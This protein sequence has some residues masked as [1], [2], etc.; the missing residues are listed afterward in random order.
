MCYD[1]AL[2]C[3]GEVGLAS[4]V[5]DQLLLNPNAD[6]KLLLKGDT[7]VSSW[8]RKMVKLLPSADFQIQVLMVIDPDE[9]SK[10]VVK[11][12]YNTQEK[13]L[14]FEVN[15]HIKAFQVVSSAHKEYIWGV[16]LPQAVVQVVTKIEKQEVTVYKSVDEIPLNSKAA[17]NQLRKLFISFL[18]ENEEYQTK[19]SEAIPVFLAQVNPNIKLGKWVAA[20]DNS[21]KAVKWLSKVKFNA[22][23]ST[24]FEAPKPNPKAERQSEKGGNN[25]KVIPPNS[26]GETPKKEPKVTSTIDDSV[27]ETFNWG[28]DED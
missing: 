2:A 6:P 19:L 26:D 18:K 16:D 23:K 7:N 9:F 20:E 22:E 27:S 28:D 12:I 17:E 8:W 4:L 11:T 24:D 21:E 1:I 3:L 5:S 14:E 13:A 25:L 10:C 15:P